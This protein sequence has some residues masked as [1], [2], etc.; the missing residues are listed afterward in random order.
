MD[1]RRKLE[2][3]LMSIRQQREQLRALLE[4]TAAKQ[5]TTRTVRSLG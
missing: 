2:A 3:R 5:L 4:L 1:A